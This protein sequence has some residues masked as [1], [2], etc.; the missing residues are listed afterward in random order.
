MDA[1]YVNTTTFMVDGD[2]TIE[3]NI[4]R[5]V[6]ITLNSGN[7]YSTVTGSTY[8]SPTDKTSVQIDEAILDATLTVV[9]Y[10]VVSTGEYGSMP[11]HTHDGSEGSGGTISG[12][13][14]G[15][16]S[17]FL[18]L[19]DTPSSY[20]DT[21]Y[22]RS[23]ASG[24]EWSEVD[25]TTFSGTSVHVD[26]DATVTGTV[27]AHVYD[28]YSPL[29]IKDGGITVVQGDGSGV[30]D[31]PAGATISGATLQDGA[32]G[33]D[34]NI[35]TVASGV[36]NT[37]PNTIGDMYL[38]SSNYNV[39]QATSAS[40]VVTYGTTDLCTNGTAYASS[41][42]LDQAW[43]QPTKAFDNDTGTWWNSA[44]GAGPH[45]WIG[46]EF[47]SAIAVGKIR[48]YPYSDSNYA[49]WK[50]QGTNDAEADW[51][52]KVWTDLYTETS[53]PTAGWNSYETGNQT[54]YKYYRL[55]STSVSSNEWPL[56]ELE[57]FQTIILDAYELVGNIKGA[58]GSDAPT[59]FSGL[60][61]T[62]SS[63]DDGKYLRSTS[64]GTEWSEISDSPST[65]LDLTDTPTTYSG[66]VGKFLISTAS[67]IEFSSY[68]INSATADFYAKI[69]VD[70]Y[71]LNN[72]VLSQ[73]ISN[74][75]GNTDTRW[76]I[77]WQY[78]NSS[79]NTTF[80]LRFNSDSGSSYYSGYIGELNDAANANYYETASTYLMVNWNQASQHTSGYSELFLKSGNRRSSISTTESTDAVD[81]N[82]HLVS[83]RGAWT[84]TEDEV[85]SITLFTDHEISGN[86]R[87]YKFSIPTLPVVS[88][89]GGGTS[90]VQTFLDLTDTP[91]TYSGTSGQYM[92]STGSGIEFSAGPSMVEST[93]YADELVKEWSLT[94]SG[95]DETFDWDGEN[96]EAYIEYAI[97]NNT[98]P[99]AFVVRPNSDTTA[100]YGFS[101]LYVTSS[102]S[103]TYSWNAD[104]AWEGF[105]LAGTGGT[106][107]IYYRGKFSSNLKKNSDSR[108]GQSWHSRS[109]DSKQVFYVTRWDDT[110]SLV[111]SLN[112]NLS[113]S[114]TG[115]VKL[116]KKKRVALPTVE[117]EVNLY[118]GKQS[119]KVKWNSTSSFDCLPGNVEIGGTLYNIASTINKSTSSLTASTWYYVYVNP[120]STGISLAAANIEYSTTAPTQNTTLMGQYN[121]SKRCIGAIYSNSS[122]QI[123]EFLHS[124]VYYKFSDFVLVAADNV[125]PSDT[126]TDVIMATPFANSIS[127]FRLHCS[128]S[129]TATSFYMRRK[130]SS[131][132]GIGMLYLSS[133][134]ADIHSEF[135]TDSNKKVEI[136]WGASTTNNVYIYNTG[137]V[138]PDDIY[139]GV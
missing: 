113:G 45:Y 87:I 2:R 126:W 49:L 86:V 36:P 131:S 130:G 135:A 70:E 34:G 134:R 13:G 127:M 76:V 119:I 138:L 92:V 122:S 41:V 15:G 28:S 95:I 109:D 136:R 101:A 125:T 115:F 128:Y 68:S 89:T 39:Y 30:I 123:A 22:L 106:T 14:G 67:G 44:Y 59:T 93:F 52:S 98:T 19:T 110:S 57:F 55:I 112:V 23:T 20:D 38:D 54:A 96:E 58:D 56:R 79:N 73:T 53:A 83:Y 37:V 72:E 6:K 88:G 103:A 80:A 99:M 111:T 43:Y 139:T 26:G 117:T 24:T 90:D 116:F 51:D 91:T 29:T 46:Y 17:T 129:N 85:S 121:G 40:G 97:T 84:N 5:R 11:D 31:F 47:S 94:A 118:R 61:D 3:F 8:S 21:K 27:Y 78:Q 120:P 66:Q 82:Y 16:A 50:F 60:S 104:L 9:M 32:D 10:G 33:A 81:A 132:N 108:I 137:F 105:A 4:G 64:S 12:T 62:P 107:P 71:T 69:L 18:E 75:Y 35:W 65:F 48:M 124:S 63:Y 42:Y 133:G 77:E 102:P 74:V 114:C 25:L 1:T 7:V 100:A